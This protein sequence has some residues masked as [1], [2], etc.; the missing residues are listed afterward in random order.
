MNIQETL[1]F[2][3]QN[4]DKFEK[5]GNKFVYH[6][7]E[8]KF[9]VVVRGLFESDFI[10]ISRKLFWFIYYPTIKIGFCE[11]VGADRYETY[12]SLISQALEIVNKEQ[13]AKLERK[14]QKITR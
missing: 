4:F 1:G 6:V 12:R 14:L 11:A 7:G 5:R 10:R 2:I 8:V 3:S 13:R 9:K